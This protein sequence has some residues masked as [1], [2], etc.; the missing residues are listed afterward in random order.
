MR[1]I[2][3]LGAVN[4]NSLFHSR[5][6]RIRGQRD[7]S[8]SAIYTCLG[9]F[10]V[11]DVMPIGYFQSHGMVPVC[12]ANRKHGINKATNDDRLKASSPATLESFFTILLD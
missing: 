7:E 9:L 5:S 8:F 10:R 12:V 2:L 1:K 4:I 6:Q 3:K 11:P